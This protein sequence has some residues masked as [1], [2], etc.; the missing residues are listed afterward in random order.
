MH[1]LS[2]EI[3]KLSAYAKAHGK[4]SVDVSDVD[5][6]CCASIECDAFAISNAIIEKNVEK[7]FLA[8]ADMKEQR[9][10]AGA[11][12]AQIAKTYGDLMSV[13]LFSEE[14]KSASDIA[15]I[16]KFHPYKLGLYMTAAKKLGSKRIAESLSML[17]KTDASSKSGGISGYEAVEIFITKNIGR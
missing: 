2:F 14:G 6:I 11:A 10:D 4:P 17:L 5:E 3:E 1:A 13:S 16:M 9:L 8:L 15:A 7:A 12:L